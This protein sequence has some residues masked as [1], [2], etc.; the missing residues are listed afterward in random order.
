MM[1]KEPV[2]VPQDILEASIKVREYLLSHSRTTGATLNGLSLN[3]KEYY[4][5]GFRDG[6]KN[7]QVQL[8]ALLN[9]D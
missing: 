6:R 1:N 7:L 5:L 2:D 4:I 3:A 8:S 9:V